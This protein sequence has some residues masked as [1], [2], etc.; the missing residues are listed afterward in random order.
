VRAFAAHVPG[1]EKH[2]CKFIFR[3]PEL[4]LSELARMLGLLCLPVMNE[5]RFTWLCVMTSRT[6]LIAPGNSLGCDGERKATFLAHILGYK[7]HQCKLF[8]SLP[9]LDPN[10][11]DRL[12]GLLRLPVVKEKR[13][14]SSYL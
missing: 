10:V 8:F 9:V 5:V 13:S 4:D 6:R 12:P 3:L 2:Q 11:S 7:E 14:P 1:Y